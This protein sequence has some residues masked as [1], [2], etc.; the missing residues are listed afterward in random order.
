MTT[1][2]VS[3]SRRSRDRSIRVFLVDPHPI[4]REGIRL[5]LADPEFSI[6]GEAGTGEEAIAATI[7][8][9]PDVVLLE[10]VLPDGPGRE[11]CAAILERLPDAAV[12]IL[13]ALI[14]SESVRGAF[15][16][17]ARAFLVKDAADLDLPDAIRRALK[18]ESIIHP[19]AASALIGGLGRR[20]PESPRLSQQ[21]IKILQ[22]VAQGLTN[23]EIG[24]RLYLSRHTVKEYLGHAMHK[25]DASSR[26]AAV[27]EA[28]RRGLID[29]PNSSPGAG[30]DN[31][32]R[33][34]AHRQAGS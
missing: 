32:Y 22:L 33:G 20:S 31:S 4:F 27:L 14:D 17:G 3:A 10:L 21:E 29:V 13:S 1:A 7:R 24:A 28:H 34:R 23:R 12:I 11:V 18:G 15:D 16:A 9:R 19:R 6:V 8:A 25:L 30:R 5:R 26:V 2:K